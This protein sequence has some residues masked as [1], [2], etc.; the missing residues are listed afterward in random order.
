MIYV[1]WKLYLHS[2]CFNSKC[3]WGINDENVA[4]L[5]LK[6]E[7]EYKQLMSELRLTTPTC[8]KSENPLLQGHAK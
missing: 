6:T 3:C 1:K 5:A 8:L 4:E 7:F 2:M